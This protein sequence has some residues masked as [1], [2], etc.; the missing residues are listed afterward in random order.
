MD[1]Q[2]LPHLA[3]DRS[4]EQEYEAQLMF[5]GRFCKSTGG[6]LE[7]KRGLGYPSAVGIL[8]LVINPEMD[9][10]TII[11]VFILFL[12][13]FYDRDEPRQANL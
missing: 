6:D 2:Y 3:V 9:R 12:I 1:S 11:I 7:T 8:D 13:S 4:H 10:I 5:N